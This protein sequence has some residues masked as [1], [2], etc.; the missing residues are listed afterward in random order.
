MRN[1]IVAAGLLGIMLC[2]GCATIVRGTH[3]SLGIRTDPS[4]AMVAVDG[5]FYTTPATLDL[6]RR[7]SH[8]VAITKDGYR[9]ILF[10]LEPQ[11]D[12]TSLVGNLILPGG[13]VGLVYDSANGADKAFFQLA[14][15]TLVPATRPTDPALVL[16][17]YKGH[18]LTDEQFA[19][20]AVYDKN[21]RSQFFRGE[22]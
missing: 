3:Q 5:K 17:D 6:A 15:I 2:S 7:S 20:A 14:T 8:N 11:W 21:D 9:P 16:K 1:L 4:G 13:S 10:T 18:L 22:P 12:G 19:A